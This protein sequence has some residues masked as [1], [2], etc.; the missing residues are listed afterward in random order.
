MAG[1]IVGGLIEATPTTIGT[2]QQYQR[3]TF[4]AHGLV[5]SIIAALGTTGEHLAVS[6]SDDDGETWTTPTVIVEDF[7]GG[8]GNYGTAAHFDGQYLHIVV[9]GQG[10]VTMR[11]RRGEPQSDGT[12]DWSHDLQDVIT[13]TDLAEVSITAVNGYPVIGYEWFNDAEP[14]WPR[15][16][17][18]MSA[19][20]DG[21]WVTAD[22][23]PYQLDTD[24]TYT[25]IGVGDLGDGALLAL[26]WDTSVIK[27]RV[28]DNE[29]WGAVESVDDEDP[30]PAAFNYTAYGY[31]TDPETGRAWIIYP[32]SDG[33]AVSKMRDPD[34]GWQSAE[35]VTTDPVETLA[36]GFDAGNETL[37]AFYV[38]EFGYEIKYAVNDGSGWD[39]GHLLWDISLDGN[40]GAVPG[41]LQ[42]SERADE[43]R[44]VLQ[45]QGVVGFGVGGVHGITITVDEPPPPPPLPPSTYFALRDEYTVEFA[46]PGARTLGE[47]EVFYVEEAPFSPIPTD[48]ATLSL[49]Y[50]TTDSQDSGTMICIASDHEDDHYVTLGVIPGNYAFAEFNGQNYTI[51]YETDAAQQIGPNEWHHFAVVF[52]HDKDE[53]DAPLGYATVYVDGV[54]GFPTWIGG[55]IP[56]S[57]L[58]RTCI[59]AEWGGHQSTGWEINGVSVGNQRPGAYSHVY[60]FGHALTPEEVEALAGL[61]PMVEFDP[62]WLWLLH[63]DD[64][65]P[66]HDNGPDLSAY[67]TPGLTA[68]PLLAPEPVVHEPA[69]TY[70]ALREEYTVA[71]PEPLVARFA[72]RDEYTVA[73]PTDEPTRTVVR[74]YDGRWMATQRRRY[75]DGAWYPPI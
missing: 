50:R 34:L 65:E 60:V 26:W 29:E 64:P 21:T 10:E 8:V 53:G 40:E 25:W 46:G 32:S 13:E 72:L 45:Y 18:I 69:V 23:F 54:P 56:P 11:Y 44:F 68:H 38:E 59:G 3:E 73:E 35:Q 17:V 71:P 28:W 16:M 1:E 39:D 51:A 62:T 4:A 49:W 48:G 19:T 9:S 41:S 27:A 24:A 12:I 63:G 67:G 7:S 37:Y 36:L 31:V 66:E 22:D 52:G 30:T 15:P 6:T 55:T 74:W 47:N 33:G 42:V 57:N 20:N 61:S 5:W 14:G 58:D 70:F 2:G 43:G 75:T